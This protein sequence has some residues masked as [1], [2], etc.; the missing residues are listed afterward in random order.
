[1]SV[2]LEHFD[3]PTINLSPRYA[4]NVYRVI[5]S[6]PAP[7]GQTDERHGGSA[8]IRSIERVVR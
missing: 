6:K 4:A 3:Y 7:D 8:M 1:M 5:T 2:C